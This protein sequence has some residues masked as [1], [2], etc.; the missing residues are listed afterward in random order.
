MIVRYVYSACVTIETPDLRICCDPWFGRAYEGSWAQYPPLPADPVDVIGEVDWIYVSHIHPD[1]YDPVFL[2]RY[3]DRHPGTR[4]VVGRTDPPFLARKAAADGFRPE[5][6]ERE[7]VGGTEVLI[8][9]N[10]GYE[11][12]NVDTALAVRRD[13]LSVVNL[14]DNPFDAAQLEAIRAFCPGGRPDAALLPYA[15]A[16][17]YPQTY[18]FDSDEALHAAAERKRRQFLEVFDRY[19]LAL[20]PR[21]A[22]PFAGKYW[23]VGPLA[24]RNASR[25]VADAVEAATRHRGRALVLADGGAATLDVATGRASAVRTEPYDPAAVDAHLESLPFDGYG[26]EREIRPEAGHA[27]PLRPLLERAYERALATHRLARP[28]WLCIRPRG[29]DVFFVLDLAAREARLETRKDV[30]DLSPRLEHVVDER[31]LYGLLTRLYHWNNAEIG[32]HL[33]TTRVPDRY[34]PE[35]HVFLNHLHV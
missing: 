4:L 23:L 18:A 10:H 1:H 24:R 6:V 20:D 9:A 27:L 35:V 8:V 32:S 26:Y 11:A 19:V 33:D 17:P 7:R 28:A 13:E 25:G 31:H 3:L 16:G 5:V 15:G 22:I 34:R 14:N 2:R 21:V 12:D 29:S 30:T